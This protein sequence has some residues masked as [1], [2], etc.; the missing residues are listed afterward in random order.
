MSAA[1]DASEDRGFHLWRDASGWRNLVLS[2]VGLTAV[3]IA[4]PLLVATSPDQ[5][6]AQTAQDAQVVASC[7]GNPAAFTG[8]S[9]HGQI[10]GFLSSDQ[11]GKVLQ[12]TQFSS[13]MAISPDYLAN[14]RSLVHLD[15]RPDGSKT[16]YLV[17][18]GMTVRIGEQVDVVSGHVDP[19]LP[20]HYV[21]NLIAHVQP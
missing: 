16:V 15:G 18:Q 11:A 20:C 2:A 9:G 19:S 5:S 17:P 12:N 21:P 3:S 13:R 14:V 6:V 10:V 4:F 1:T 8:P 7:H